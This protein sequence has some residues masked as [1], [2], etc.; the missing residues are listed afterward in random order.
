MPLNINK[1]KLTCANALLFITE[2]LKHNEANDE[3]RHLWDVLTALRGPDNRDEELKAA[4]TEVIRDKA[5][6][7]FVV[8]HFANVNSDTPER[9][10]YREGMHQTKEYNT[11]HFEH[12]ARAAFLALDLDWDTEDKQRRK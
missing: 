4:T 1:K 12:H 8:R 9:M 11:A 2:V 6:G 10:Q 7:R 5:F 3:G